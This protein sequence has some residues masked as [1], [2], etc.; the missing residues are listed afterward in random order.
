[1]DPLRLS[2]LGGVAVGPPSASLAI[3]GPQAGAQAA[4]EAQISP[5]F[6]DSLLAAL[7]APSAAPATPSAADT[8]PAAA[9]VPPAPPAITLAGALPATP[10]IPA[11]EAV[12]LPRVTLPDSSTAAFALETALRFGAGVAPGPGPV[13]FRP[14]LTAAPIRDAAAVPRLPALQPQTGG[15]GPEAYA[16]PQVATPQA[17]NAYR[18]AA[19][20]EPPAG[21]DLLA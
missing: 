3:P 15:P 21:L 7:S 18:T 13:E 10:V 17:V 11:S 20:A 2:P 19:V 1:M 8:T 4:T 12:A 6:T 5:G 9:A 14:D 16:Q